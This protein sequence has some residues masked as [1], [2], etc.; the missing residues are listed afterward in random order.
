MEQVDGDGKPIGVMPAILLVPPALSAMA[1][2]LNKA[3]E[4]RDTTANQKYPIANPHQG[5]YRAEVSRY[6]SNT[7]YPGNSSKAWYLL[8]A[9]GDLAVIEVA[10]LNGQES[11]TI[12]TAEADFNVLGVQMRGYHD[13]GVALQDPRGGVK[14][15]GEV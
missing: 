3:L 14:S 12:E 10:F 7:T 2:Q 6:L 15:K 5:K 11:P 4:I 1:S 13:F 9:A 8:A